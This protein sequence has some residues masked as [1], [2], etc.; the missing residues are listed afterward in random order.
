MTI[1][2]FQEE[3]KMEETKYHPLPQPEEIAIREKEDAMGSYLMMFAAMGAGLPLPIINLIAAVIYYY[4]N[5]SKSRFVNFHSYQAMMS[6]IPTS[7]LNAGLTFWGIRI[8]VSEDWVFSNEF[9][10]Y[11]VMVIIANLL[12]IIFSIIAAIKARKGR[13]YYFMFFGKLAYH[14]TYAVR[15]EQEKETIINLPPKL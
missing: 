2:L 6:Q 13:F 9:K 3:H 7:L 11:V 8:V 10:G 14:K 12:Y 15:I 4:I 5:K 1:L